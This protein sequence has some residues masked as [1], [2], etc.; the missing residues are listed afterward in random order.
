[1]FDEGLPKH[2][3]DKIYFHCINKY[4]TGC[5]RLFANKLHTRWNYNGQPDGKR[6]T[7]N[8]CLV[9]LSS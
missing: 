8:H 2:K 3:E 9:Y 1:M 6:R 5:F 4:N 7:R